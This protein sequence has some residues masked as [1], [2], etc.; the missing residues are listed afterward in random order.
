MFV[1]TIYLLLREMQLYE[2]IQ[3]IALYQTCILLYTPNKIRCKY[4]SLILTIV[5]ILKYN[6][7][8]IYTLINETIM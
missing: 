5:N 3:N 7:S 2:I 8:Y 4:H 1:S 6:I